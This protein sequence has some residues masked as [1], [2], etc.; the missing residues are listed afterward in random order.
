MYC[1]PC[2]LPILYPI[3]MQ[4]HTL[5]SIMVSSTRKSCLPAYCVEGK[6][7]AIWTPPAL[8]GVQDKVYN[9][10]PTEGKT[11]NALL[12]VC[13]CVSRPN[14]KQPGNI[15]EFK[16]L[17]PPPESWQL[18]SDFRTSYMTRVKAVASCTEMSQ[19]RPFHFN[20]VFNSALGYTRVGTSHNS[21]LFEWLLLDFCCTTC[22]KQLPPRAG[23][24]RSQQ[25]ENH[26]HS[27]NNHCLNGLGQLPWHYIC[28]QIEL[29]EVARPLS[30]QILK[31]LSGQ[32]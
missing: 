1:I 6:C 4:S 16:L 2:P 25:L 31:R 8:Q 3:L 32:H 7:S 24:S 9:M 21:F 20:C 30:H 12:H 29:A 13:T 28:K 26:M 18:Q 19:S 17:I 14:E 5:W 22:S 23:K 15:C 10:W 27:S 11:C